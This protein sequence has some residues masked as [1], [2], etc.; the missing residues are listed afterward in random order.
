MFRNI[1]CHLT[2][3]R[4]GCCAWLLYLLLW[5]GLLLLLFENNN[6]VFPIYDRCSFMNYQ[7]FHLHLLG[8]WLLLLRL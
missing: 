8:L 6:I 2:S 4:S 7:L 5:L 1:G 3:W